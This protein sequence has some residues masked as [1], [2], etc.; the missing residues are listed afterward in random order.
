MCFT[1]SSLFAGYETGQI[2][3][4]HG[5]HYNFSS[6]RTNDLIEYDRYIQQRNSANACGQAIGFLIGLGIAK[7]VQSAVTSHRD[8][9]V[10]KHLKGYDFDHHNKYMA[11][12]SGTD[13]LKDKHKFSLVSLIS[14]YKN[15]RVDL[16][17]VYLE[18]IH[19]FGIPKITYWECDLDLSKTPYLKNEK[20]ERW[21][22]EYYHTE[23]TQNDVLDFIYEYKKNRLIADNEL[24]QIYYSILK[25]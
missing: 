23:K 19:Q 8:H 25:S 12:L 17:K 7:G 10:E 5:N 6:Y 16:D 13:E 2:S 9:V 11:I 21:V 18:K 24:G 20:I 14:S 22:K 4:N 15:Y 3:D 1:C